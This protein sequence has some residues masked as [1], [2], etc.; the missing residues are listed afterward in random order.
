MTEEE[1]KRYWA[2]FMCTVHGWKYHPGRKQD[3]GHSA[4][5]TSAKDADNMLKHMEERWPTGQQQ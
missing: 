5:E 2:L 1:R 3:P 4:M